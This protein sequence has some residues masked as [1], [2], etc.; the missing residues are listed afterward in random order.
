MIDAWNTLACAAGDLAAGWMLWLPRDVALVLLAVLSAALALVLR[1]FST[2]PQALRAIQQ[3]LQQLKHLKRTARAAGDRVSLT[4]FRR[5]AAAVRWLQLRQEFRALLV[6][7]V[8]LAILATWASQ[9]FAFLPPQSKQP[10][11][12]SA[13][14]PPSAAGGVIHL[15]PEDGVTAATGWIQEITASRRGDQ[16]RGLATWTVS[17]AAR[18]QGYSFTLRF[19][20]HSVEHPIRVGQRTYL[21]PRQVHG[22]DLETQ[23]DLR[24]YRP[25][26]LDWVARLPLPAWLTWYAMLV[27]L[28]LSFQRLWC[29]FGSQRQFIPKAFDD[30]V[31]GSE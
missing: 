16:P 1:R 7:L 24:P 6:S 22:D 2:N 15:M 20:G 12:V 17:A 13:W 29:S 4:R 10:F 23:V 31:V 5:T 9:R 18:E 14:L 26:G 21:P 30:A 3:D 27:A 19:R 25:L 8:P 28:A 11:S